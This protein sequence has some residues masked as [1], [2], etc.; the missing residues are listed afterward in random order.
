MKNKLL[1]LAAVIAV[2]FVVAAAGFGYGYTRENDDAFCASCHTE[3]ESTYFDRSTAA[4]AVD[5]ASFH[6]GEETRCIDCHSGK[7]L[8]GRANAMLLGARDW[9][10]FQSGSYDQP[11]QTTHPED[12]DSCTKCH[13]FSFWGGEAGEGPSLDGQRGHDGHY[14][15]GRLLI[16]WRVRGGPENGCSSCHPAH[17]TMSTT[18]FSSSPQVEEGCR[19]CHDRLGEGGGE[20]ERD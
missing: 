15:S 3:P 9:I 7:G 12:N 6:H 1:V 4:D 18:S 14:H 10:V 2:F 11:A 5:L 17:V 8:T 20:G 16:T 19:S 13:S